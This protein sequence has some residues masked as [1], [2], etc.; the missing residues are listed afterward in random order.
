MKADPGA[1]RNF[2]PHKVAQA[3]Q[4]AEE[5]VARLRAEEKTRRIQLAKHRIELP[6]DGDAPLDRYKKRFAESSPSYRV[7]QPPAAH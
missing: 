7:P 3:K 6:K 1:N 4:L 2:D 5:L